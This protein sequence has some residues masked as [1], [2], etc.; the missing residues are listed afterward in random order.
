[1]IFF[2]FIVDCQW[3]AWS[4]IT[5]TCG[6]VMRSRKVHIEASNGGKECYGNKTEE[7]ILDP[8]PS[9]FI[10]L[11]LTCGSYVIL[12]FFSFIVDC[13]WTAWSPITKTCG[14]V[15]RSRK[16]HSEATNGGKECYANK[17]EEIILDPCPGNFIIICTVYT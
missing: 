13:Q 1:M 7:T 16:V 11:Y 12:I 8:C 10:V 14:V 4:P 3:T 6:V 2:S 17:M 9:N 5:K 15:M